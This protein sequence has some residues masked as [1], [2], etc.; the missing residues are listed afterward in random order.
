M[1]QNMNTHSSIINLTS[2]G[3]FADFSFPLRG[4]NCRGY[5]A[6]EVEVTERGWII[7][8]WSNYIHQV[9]W[10]NYPLQTAR[11]YAMSGILFGGTFDKVQSAIQ[12]FELWDDT[13]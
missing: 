10:W 3:L 12:L 4:E 8:S 5:V 1:K 6:Y 2:A 11:Q 9:K 13:E 7:N